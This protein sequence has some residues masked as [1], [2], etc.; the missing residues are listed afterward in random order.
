MS[1]GFWKPTEEQ[2]ETILLLE[3]LALI[4]DLGKLSGCFLLHMEPP[5]RKP[6]DH[7]LIVDPRRL[8]IFVN[9]R[10]DINDKQIRTAIKQ[11]RDWLNHANDQ[12]RIKPFNLRQDL[13]E[14]LDSIRITDW[15]D[16]TYTLAELTPFLPHPS[17]CSVKSAW[18]EILGKSMEP[19]LLVAKMHGVAHI[20]KEGNPKNKMPYE[21]VYRSTPFG[22]EEQVLKGAVDEL[23][24]ALNDLPL[25]RI[26]D[27]ASPDR[28]TWLEEMR[29]GLRHGLADNRRPHNE[30]SLWD[31]G[32]T[33]AAFTKAAAVWIIK[34]GGWPEDIASISIRTL[35]ISLDYLGQYTRSAKIS[36]LLGVRAELIKSFDM[37]Q[38]FLESQLALG[39]CIYS[40]ETGA[41]YLIPD[42]FSESEI[43]ELSLQIQSNFLPDL[44]P[45]IWLGESITISQLDDNKSL[46]SELVAKIRSRVK[47]AQHVSAEDNLYLFQAEWSIDRPENAEVCSA[48]GVRPV[49]Y[50]R[51]DRRSKI[52]ELLEPWAKEQKARERKIC[53]LC[54]SRRGRPSKDWVVGG[55]K[56]TIWTDEVADNHGRLALLVGKLGLEGWL[57]GNLISTILV[58][59]NTPSDIL[60]QPSPARLYRI[61]E[62]GRN[63][64]QRIM[65]KITPQIVAQRPYRLALN[66]SSDFQPADL[67]EYHTYEFSVNG[68]AIS[69]VWDK[70][71]HRFITTENLTYFA[72][73]ARLPVDELAQVFEEHTFTLLEPSEYLQPSQKLTQLHISR[74]DLMPG[75]EPIIPLLTEPSLGMLLIPAQDALKLAQAVKEEYE[76]EFGRVRDRL[77]LALGLVFFNRH[78]PIRAVLDAGQAMLA[79]GK[80]D[81]WEGWRLEAI[82]FTS[83]SGICEL[84]FTNGISWRI[85]IR[86]GDNETDDDWYPRLYMGENKSQGESVCVTKLKECDPQKLLEKQNQVWVLPSWFDFEYL[87]TTGRRFEIDYSRHGRRPRPTRPYHLEDLDRMEQIWAYLKRL[88]SAQL[89]QTLQSIEL[90]REKWFGQ[91]LTVSAEDEV[92]RQFVSDTLAQA[93]WPQNQPWS[94][95]PEPDRQMIINAG[96]SGVLAD[97]LELHL[98]ILRE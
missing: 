70:P 92:F 19:A 28:R 44:R 37:T 59:S 65:D 49:G 73:R 4:H 15:N 80:P 94:G 96:T 61:A 63:F 83:D 38:D 82:D 20:E 75:Y 32:F 91:N 33:T 79:M 88:K 6:Y 2:R 84:A 54:L 9:A 3:A 39:N 11:V 93:N 57:D 29:Q 56:Y 76:R 98:E 16:E 62:T 89:R 72:Q 47:D 90:T 5:S 12:E 95:I 35:C 52:D 21:K 60:K 58:E 67:G 24:E 26:I 46:C 23:T 68:V 97:L 1:A 42:V 25:T 36:D 66:T 85:P 87:D 10:L 69:V 17:L 30:I 45:R 74:V 8:S 41:Y 53:R 13:T 78:T 64:W 50:P 27:I 43:K 34:N 55:C 18:K 22:V 48:C 77:P 40:D 71:N 31:W 14:I 51:Q 81:A 7:E 86:A